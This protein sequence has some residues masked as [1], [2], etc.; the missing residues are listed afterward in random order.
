MLNITECVVLQVRKRYTTF[1]LVIGSLEV[2]GFFTL[3]DGPATY[4]S[5]RGISAE[6]VCSPNSHFVTKA[7]GTS[8]IV[9]VVILVG[10]VFTNWLV[11]ALLFYP[12]F[13]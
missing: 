7:H 9:L 4:I 12:P 11:F 13:L 8:D 10:V 5:P 1:S 2:V 6:Y 3:H